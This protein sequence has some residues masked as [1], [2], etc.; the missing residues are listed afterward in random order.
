M[1]CNKIFLSAA[2]SEL[3]EMICVVISGLTFVWVLSADPGIAWLLSRLHSR[4]YRWVQILGQSCLATKISA[5]GPSSFGWFRHTHILQNQTIDPWRWQ[6]IQ[7]DQVCAHVWKVNGGNEILLLWTSLPFIWTTWGLGHTI[8]FFIFLDLHL[9]KYI[10]SF[11][12]SFL[13]HASWACHLFSL[14]FLIAHA[15]FERY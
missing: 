10:F 12:F 15:S 13:G 9:S 1:V 2:N 7:V 3:Y 5:P 11:L 8:I 14:F 4:N 6:I